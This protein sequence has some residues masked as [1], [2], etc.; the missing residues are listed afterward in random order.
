MQNMRDISIR[1]HEMRNI[2]YMSF[3]N[4]NVIRNQLAAVLTRTV[5]QETNSE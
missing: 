1:L 2:I 3:G 5:M 4:I